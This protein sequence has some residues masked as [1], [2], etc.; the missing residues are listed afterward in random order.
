MFQEIAKSAHSQVFPNKDRGLQ[1]LFYGG[2]RMF[3]FS[4]FRTKLEPQQ[5]PNNVDTYFTAQPNWTQE[6]IDV[7]FQMD[8]NFEQEPYSVW[9]DEVNLLA[10]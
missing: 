9:L 4:A 8:G 6:E 1:L 3:P 5:S 10:N 2:C 7:A